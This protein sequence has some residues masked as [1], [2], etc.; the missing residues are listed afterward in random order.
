MNGITY[1]HTRTRCGTTA[2]HPAVRFTRHCY[3]H[4]LR[5]CRFG[6][7]QDVL[8]VVHCF[9]RRSV[10]VIPTTVTSRYP[11]VRYTCARYI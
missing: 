10:R 4:L 1:D 6:Y 2:L 8:P 5:C 7:T 3:L 11:Y 9:Y